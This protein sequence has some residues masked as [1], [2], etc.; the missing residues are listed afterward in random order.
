MEQEPRGF[1]SD[2][3]GAGD[4][5]ARHT[6]S[7]VCDHPHSHEPAFQRDRLIFEYGA[8]LDGELA[9]SVPRLALPDAPGWD[10]GDICT[11]AGRAGDAIRP[12]TGYEVSN[13]V[14]GVIEEDDGFLKSL[15]A[16]IHHAIMAGE[17]RKSMG[18]AKGWSI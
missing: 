7:A 18:Q 3:Q 9:F 10:V 5:V 4:L 8:D 12:A 16:I 15:R 11:T 13:A 14:V 17:N 1:L 2:T 6:V